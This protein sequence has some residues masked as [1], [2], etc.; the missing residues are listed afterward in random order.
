MSLFIKYGIHIISGN[1]IISEKFF[2]HFFVSIS[3]LFGENLKRTEIRV[4][5]IVELELTI[6]SAYYNQI[7]I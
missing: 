4:L 5:K 7:Y 3:K 2:C 6:L 1:R